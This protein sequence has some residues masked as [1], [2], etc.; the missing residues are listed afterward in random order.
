MATQP[1]T[2]K[3]SLSTT[4]RLPGYYIGID[5]DHRQHNWQS[6]ERTIYVRTADGVESHDLSG[7][8]APLLQWSIHVVVAC[9]GRWWR[10]NILNKGRGETLCGET[11]DQ[12]LCRIVRD[13]L[14]ADR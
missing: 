11:I 13:R 2:E 12:E 10:D 14:E 7:I 3:A 9:D 8:E 1:D 4:D 6:T 5:A